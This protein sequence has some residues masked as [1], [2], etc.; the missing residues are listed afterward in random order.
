M[1][2]KQVDI[3]MIDIEIWTLKKHVPLR[4]NLISFYYFLF[5]VN[6]KV[7]VS[8]KRHLYY[9]YFKWG[10]RLPLASIF[11]KKGSITSVFCRIFPN[12]SEQLH[13]VYFSTWLAMRIIAISSLNLLLY[14]SIFFHK[15]SFL[16]NH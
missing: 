5:V 1:E 3:Y 13:A 7:D 4:N 14:V 12:F 2:R 10:F 15:M 8:Y 11:V 6:L 16:F 9:S